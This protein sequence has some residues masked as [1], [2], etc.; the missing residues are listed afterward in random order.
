[1]N[2]GG[3][4]IDRMLGRVERTLRKA[5]LAPE[6][7]RR[8]RGLA[9]LAMDRRAAGGLGPE[10]HALMHPARTLFILT[11]DLGLGSEPVLSA[12]VLLDSR[13]P[14]WM[15]SGTEIAEIG[16]IAELTG[17]EEEPAGEVLRIL[18]AVPRPSWRLEVGTAAGSVA[19]DAAGDA[20]PPPAPGTLADRD[21][22]LLEDLVTARPDVTDLALAEA[23]DHLRHLHL[24]PDRAA[25]ERGLQLVRRAYLPVAI[26]RGGILERRYR[27]W[28]RTF[29]RA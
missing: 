23:L 9:E 10:H 17:S 12:G 18:D 29:S 6:A 26:R 8:V 21:A 1:V 16:E 14:E 28:E 11:D 15:P 5:S 20:A 3:D 22:R 19:A 7:V 4:R 2:A 27:W 13:T 24:E 25:L